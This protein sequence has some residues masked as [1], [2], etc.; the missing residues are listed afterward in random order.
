[1]MRSRFT[2]TPGSVFMPSTED[3]T[4]AMIMDGP[5]DDVRLPPELGGCIEDVQSHHLGPCPHCQREVRHLVLKTVNVAECDQ[6]Y[7]YRRKD[8]DQSGASI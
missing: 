7:W 6:F 5:P 4:M 1:M 8:E 3:E 2:K